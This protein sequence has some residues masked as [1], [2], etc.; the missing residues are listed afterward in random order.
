ME[1]LTGLPGVLQMENGIKSG[2]TSTLVNNKNLII[3]MPLH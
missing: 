1:A 2:T 3:G